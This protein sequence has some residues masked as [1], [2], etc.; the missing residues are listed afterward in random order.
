MDGKFSNIFDLY[1]PRD[2]RYLYIDKNFSPH[3]IDYNCFLRLY[4]HSINKNEIRDK[5]TVNGWYVLWYLM[6]NGVKSHYIETTI[7]KISDDT[8]IRGNVIR[9]TLINLHEN[10]IIYINYPLTKITNT[11]YLTIAIVYNELN[12]ES[13]DGFK[14]IP[15]EYIK[16]ILNKLSPIQ[17]AIFTVLCARFSYFGVDKYFNKESGEYNYFFKENCYA[18]PTEEQMAGCTGIHRKSI[19]P[20]LEKLADLGLINIYKNEEGFIS[21]KDKETK[22]NRNKFANKIYG[23]N[24]FSRIEYA[25]HCIYSKNV[26]R[27]NNTI[28]LIKNKGFEKVANSQNQNILIDKDYIEYKLGDVMKNYEKYLSDNNSEGYK[29]L[30]TNYKVEK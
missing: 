8:G 14:I 13:K 24:I 9:D 15:T 27:D 2:S 30:R 16:T 10:D 11:T 21:Y 19:K 29:F 25:Y 17:F 18:F 23:I 1:K 28:K 12:S 22:Q 4:N 5:Y 26:N 7:S 20:N 6:S 3:G